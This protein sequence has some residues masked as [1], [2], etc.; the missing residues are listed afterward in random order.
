[1]DI[2]GTTLEVV[3]Y[4]IPAL[5]VLLSSYLIVSKFLVAQT[6]RKQLALFQDAQ[7][8]TLKLRLHAYERLV[9]FIERIH[10]RQIIPRLYDPSMTVYDLQLALTNTIKAEFEHNLSQQIYVSKNAW[11]TV[12]NVKEQ[13]IAMVNGIAKTLNPEGA[14][15]ELHVKILEFVHKSESESPTEVALHILNDEARKVLSYGAI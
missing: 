13:E 5:I 1:M 7:D 9:M 8:V 3:K 6:Q 10:P 12:R 2:A 15:K 14:A 4:T 11:E